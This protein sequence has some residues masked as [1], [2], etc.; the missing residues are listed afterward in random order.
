MKADQFFK[1]LLPSFSKDTVLED[2]RVTRGEI[3]DT[4]QPAY[5]QA[6]DLMKNAKFKS[7]EVLALAK[8]FSSLAH[9]TQGNI[10][11][12]IDKAIPVVLSTL[13]EVEGMI[14]A[15]CADEIAAGGMTFLRAN[16]LQLVEC[17]GFFAKYARQLL[18]Y[19]QIHESAQFIQ[20][21]DEQYDAVKDHLVPAD[22]AYIQDNFQNFVMAFNALTSGGADLRKKLDAVPDVVM[23]DDNVHTLPHTAG[24]TK[25]DPL[26]LGFI[27]AWLN[28]IYHIRIAIADWQFERYKLAQA[29]LQLLQMRNLNYQRLAAGQPP[30][31]KLQKDIEYNERRIA[32]LRAKIAKM[33]RNHHG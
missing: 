32:D 2:C 15:N 27:A 20:E 7:A 31:A 1:S 30:N 33:E 22:I 17:A 5:R 3:V 18:I 12:T 10:V 11:V 19:I 21:T 23:T 26:K 28:P 6:A 8:Q 13:D 16:L 4:V 24:A 9:R 25:I 29:E 14:Q